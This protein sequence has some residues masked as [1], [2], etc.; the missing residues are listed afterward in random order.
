MGSSVWDPGTYFGYHS[1]QAPSAQQFLW[2][3]HDCCIK[4]HYPI[5]CFCFFKQ[6]GRNG[7]PDDPSFCLR[8]PWY[9]SSWL[10]LPFWKLVGDRSLAV[11]IGV[12]QFLGFPSNVVI[13]HEVSEAIGETEDERTYIEETLSIPYLV[14]G[15]TVVTI[16]S[17]TLA[18]IIIGLPFFS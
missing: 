8:L 12:E 13:C 9:S 1:F 4:F 17:T 7:I 3:G 10:V 14:G 18:G 11:G 5:S 15:I 6:S 2:P 16:L